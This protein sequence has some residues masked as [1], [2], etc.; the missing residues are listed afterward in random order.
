M[1]SATYRSGVILSTLDTLAPR[2]AHHAE[3][4]FDRVSR[5]VRCCRAH[6]A[7]LHRMIGNS[8]Q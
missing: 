4:F 6:D 1:G 8:E 5:P 3:R 2:V 7:R